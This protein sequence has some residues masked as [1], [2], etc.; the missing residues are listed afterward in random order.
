VHPNWVDVL[1]IGEKVVLPSSQWHFDQ[2][3]LDPD[4][5]RLWHG[6][7]SIALTLKAVGVLHYLVN[8]AGQLVTKEALLDALWP[9][10]AVSDAAL[11]VVI[12]ELRKALGDTAQAP[13]FIAT[14][15]R[16]GYRFLAPVTRIDSAAKGLETGPFSF[17]ASPPPENP[18][19]GERLL[20]TVL[21]GVL[22]NAGAL[23]AE[24]GLDD[25]LHLMQFVSDMPLREVQKCEGMIQHVIGGG[26]LAL[27]GVPVAQ[28]DHVQR[29]LLADLRLLQRLHER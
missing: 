7:Q 1:D 23:G 14:V 13:Q 19:S 6:D 20:V 3:R 10:T 8:H 9:N 15:H 17:V 5:A 22:L 29:P 25:L 2:F 26:L 21:G 28:E 12:S 4:N 18:R 11:R 16:L 24:V 27:F